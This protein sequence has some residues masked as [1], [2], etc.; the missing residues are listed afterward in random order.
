MGSGNATVT[1]LQNSRVFNVTGQSTLDDVTVERRQVRSDGGGIMSASC[2]GGLEREHLGD[3][4]LS[5]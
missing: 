2:L 4:Q 1:A 3:R 5:P